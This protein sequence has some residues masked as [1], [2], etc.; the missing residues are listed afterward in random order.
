MTE[1]EVKKI[2][3]EEYIG[4]HIGTHTL[5]RKYHCHIYEQF[6]KYN[7]P[8]RNDKEKNKKYICNNS[9]FENID[10]QEKAYWLGFIY[11]DGYIGKNNNNGRFGISLSTEDIDH[12][13]KF[14]ESIESSH[15]INKYRVSSGYKIG[16][17][18][19]RIIICEEKLVNDL[20]KQGC[21]YNKT[22]ILSPPNIDKKLRRHFIRGYMDGDGSIIIHKNKYCDS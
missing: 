1:D 9:Y 13:Y 17:E 5:K 19:C 6:K 11:A 4:Q 15:P 18:Y 22:N 20:I 21:V 7:L 3:Y 8:I 12:L 14:K 16:A 2:Y 10:T